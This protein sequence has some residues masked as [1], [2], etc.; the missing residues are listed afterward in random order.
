MNE[1]QIID[2]LNRC[3]CSDEL[4]THEQFAQQAAHEIMKLHEQATG[5]LL[6]DANNIKHEINKQG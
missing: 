2:I 4:Q 3:Y 6:L 5:L 1:Q